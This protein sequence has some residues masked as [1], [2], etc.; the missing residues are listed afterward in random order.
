MAFVHQHNTDHPFAGLCEIVARVKIKRQR[1]V[2]IDYRG[3][4]MWLPRSKVRMR[5]NHDGRMAIGLPVWLAKKK[6]VMR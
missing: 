5:S 1:A 4:D 6:G 3:T 2:L